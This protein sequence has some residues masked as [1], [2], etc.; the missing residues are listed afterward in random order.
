M[1]GIHA[2][3]VM[4]RANQRTVSSLNDWTRIV[5]DAKGRPVSGDRAARPQRE[6]L[7][8]DAG[9]QEALRT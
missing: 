8:G 1:A 5:R 2:G 9:R 6:D 7:D 4:V 3:D